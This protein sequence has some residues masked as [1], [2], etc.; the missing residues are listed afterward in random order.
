MV[1]R[2]IEKRGCAGKSHTGKVLRNAW[3]ENVWEIREKRR[4]Q[5]TIRIK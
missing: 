2:S 5:M 3:G 4:E 1:R